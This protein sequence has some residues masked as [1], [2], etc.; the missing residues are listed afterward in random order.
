VAALVGELADAAGQADQRGVPAVNTSRTRNSVIARSSTGWSSAGSRWRR[1]RSAPRHRQDSERHVGSAAPADRRQVGRAPAIT[2]RRRQRGAATV[3]PRSVMPQRVTS[4]IDSTMIRPDILRGAALTVAEQDRHLVDRR[5]HGREAA[6][7]LGEEG[8]PL[9]GGRRRVDRLHASP[10]PDTHGTR[11]CM[12]RTFTPSTKPVYRLPQRDSSSAVQRPVAWCPHR[13][14]SASRS[15]RRPRRRS[16]ASSCRD[17]RRVVGEVDVHRHD[18]RRSPRRGRPPNPCRYALPSPCLP[19]SVQHLDT[20]ELGRGCSASAPVPS[21]L[22]SS[23]TSTS[24]SGTAARPR[25]GRID[26]VLP[27]VVGGDDHDCTHGD[28]AA[29]RGW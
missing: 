1:R 14:R 4:S 6:H 10:T 3:R 5:A 2:H 16:R 20:A 9:G 23:T 12:S 24:A 17:H 27:L 7:Q 19:G 11:R 13:R 28:T 26:D 18:R 8:V 15:R 21:G 29:C 22:L 25:G